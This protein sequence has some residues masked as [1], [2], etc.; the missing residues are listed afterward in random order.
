MAESE[1]AAFE[2]VGASVLDYLEGLENDDERLQKIEG[3][4]QLLQFQQRYLGLTQEE[5]V[6]ATDM[7]LTEAERA[8]LD[9]LK[10]NQA[11]FDRKVEEFSRSK[12]IRQCVWLDYL[13][14]HTNEKSAVS[15][16][17]F[18]ETCKLE[19]P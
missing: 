8:T 14:G 16:P 6:H 10:D 12:Y 17:K 5:R 15:P 1:D 13:N 4:I 9:Q 7:E 3:L 18:A 11:A 2:A 19:S